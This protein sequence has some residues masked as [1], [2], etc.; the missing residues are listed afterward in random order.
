M[1]STVQFFSTQRR[2]CCPEKSPSTSPPRK[3]ARMRFA[4][5][6]IHLVGDVRAERIIDGRQ[7]VDA[8]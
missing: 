8:D 5:S 4:T 7:M 2:T 3:R 1:S 6:E